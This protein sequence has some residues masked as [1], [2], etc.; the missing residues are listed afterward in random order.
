VEELKEAVRI[1]VSDI[2]G[3]VGAPGTKIFSVL[4]KGGFGVVYHG[5]NSLSFSQKPAVPNYIFAIC[6]M[7]L[8]ASISG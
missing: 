4:G 3:S 2:G 7:S 8:V 1:A 6:C 5:A